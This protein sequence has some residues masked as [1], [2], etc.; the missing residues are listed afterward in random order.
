LAADI[1]NGAE[2]GMVPKSYPAAATK[3]HLSIVW[4]RVSVTFL[5]LFDCC[6]MIPYDYLPEL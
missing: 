6:F 3:L 1:A 4:F 2:L 5:K